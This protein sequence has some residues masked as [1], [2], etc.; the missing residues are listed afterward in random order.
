[1][2]ELPPAFSSRAV[3]LLCTGDLSSAESLIHEAATATEATGDSVAPHG[4]LGLA[5]FRGNQAEAST[6]IERTT[7]DILRR[8]EGVGLTIAQWAS[9]A[10]QPRNIT[11]ARCSPSS[12]SPHATE[13]GV[14]PPPH[15][16]A[17]AARSSKLRCRILWQG[18]P[19]TSVRCCYGLPTHPGETDKTVLSARSRL[20]ER[21]PRMYCMA[22]A[23]SAW[24][25]SRKSAVTLGFSE[26]HAKAADPADGFARARHAVRRIPTKPSESTH[27]PAVAP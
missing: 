4:A 17:P 13:R 23:S 22:G 27:R 16:G 3:M 26:M 24:P 15:R 2:T 20:V 5:A 1:L 9:S 6:L 10:H 11:C 8:G 25:F 14:R 18:R 19:R 7:K 12:T 21:P